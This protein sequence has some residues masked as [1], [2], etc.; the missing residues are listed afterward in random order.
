M[1]GFT[2][3]EAKKISRI[4]GHGMRRKNWHGSRPE[5][6]FFELNT[7]RPDGEKKHAV[8]KRMRKMAAAIVIQMMMGINQ[9]LHKNHVDEDASSNQNRKK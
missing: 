2:D 6:M 5:S 7:D 1:V 3:G 9:P 4:G 8:A